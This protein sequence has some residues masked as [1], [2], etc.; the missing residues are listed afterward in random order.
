MNHSSL[1]IFEHLLYTR[2][3]VRLQGYRVKGAQSL[4]QVCTVAGGF[5]QRRSESMSTVIQVV[6]AEYGGSLQKVYLTSKTLCREE[7]IEVMEFL[8]TSRSWSSRGDGEKVH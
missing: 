2:N 3:G 4:P 1:C 7:I 6:G 8:K 5:W